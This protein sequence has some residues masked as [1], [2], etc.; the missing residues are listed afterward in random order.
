MFL[1]LLGMKQL[2][3]LLCV[4]LVS[5]IHAQDANQLLQQLDRS[6]MSTE[7]LV[8]QR[9]PFSNL[10]LQT[11][12]SGMYSVLQSYKELAQAEQSYQPQRF[13][14]K[15]RFKSNNETIFLGIVHSTFETVDY[16]VVSQE[17]GKVKLLSDEN[18]FLQ[19]TRTVAAPLSLHKKGLATSFYLDEKLVYNTTDNKIISVV[20]DFG[21]GNGSRTLSWN[22][23]IQINYPDAGAKTVQLVVQFSDGRQVIQESTLYVSA[24]SRDQINRGPNQQDIVST[25]MPDL[26][27]YPGANNFAG[28]A[29]YEIFLS[30]DSVLDKP[31]F[32]I[33]GFDPFDTRNVDAV[34]DLLNYTD[35]SGT[36]NLGDKVRNEE[37]FDVIIVNLPQYLLLSDGVSLMNI[38]Q[39][40]DTNGDMIID[41]NDYPAGSTLVDG[42]ADFIERNAMTLV[43]LI[44]AINTQKTGAEQ[45]VIIGPSM[46]GLISRYALNYMENNG[47]THD[48]RLWMSFDS[49]H[50]GA[51]VPIGFQHL[52]NY[53]GYGL[54]TWVGDFS[55]ETLKPIV[56]GML[57]SNAARQMLVDHFEAHLASGEIA[58][59]NPSIT[60]PTPHPN[61][62]AFFNRI[63]NMTADG[64]P[65]QPRIVSMINGSGTGTPYQD[66]LGNDILPGAYVL[67]AFLEGV[68]FLTD[69]YLDVWFTPDASQTS[70]VSELWIDAPF[71]CFCD[72][73]AEAN[74]QSTATSAGVDAAM[75]GLFD[76]GALAA[77]FTGT[78]PVFDA[79]FGAL[80]VDFFNFI[81]TISGMAMKDQPNWYATPNPNSTRAPNDTPF[82]AWYMPPTNEPHVTLT[83][84]NVS[85]ALSEIVQSTLSNPV[86]DREEF[87]VE[88]PVDGILRMQWSQTMTPTSIS[89]Y[90]MTGSLVYQQELDDTLT[91]LETELPLANGLYLLTFETQENQRFH[92]K[93]VIR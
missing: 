16:S 93:I 91:T 15:A 8:T 29:E 19:H 33:D 75:G 42:G 48:T 43:T 83:E 54:D 30:P 5:I 17:N 50:L 70:K 66:K 9:T 69:A 60:V 23:P 78:D 59:F 2:Y 79:F 64:F 34:Y 86:F 85:F 3:T 18:P 36:Q 46:G 80:T 61:F 41:E 32:I 24:S 10:T 77:G 45:N 31:I 68:A 76:L 4:F 11:P 25:I 81:P 63:D 58:E 49:P 73:R 87:W 71:L 56:D 67:D 13:A 88:N 47:L 35:G 65:Q 89:I 20:A 38:N 52:F 90:S 12:Q 28:M 72:I 84:Q 37:G 55:V 39:V 7:L 26:S 22:R 27:I 44:Q 1:K 14:S 92:R 74:S 82:D 53:L 21:D 62:T 57:K 51:N 6:N 40:T